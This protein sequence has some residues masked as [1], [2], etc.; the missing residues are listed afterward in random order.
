MLSTYPP[1]IWVLSV[2]PPAP[3]WAQ[4]QEGLFRYVL[5]ILKLLNCFWNS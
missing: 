4:D 5:A 3:C 1:H 2:L